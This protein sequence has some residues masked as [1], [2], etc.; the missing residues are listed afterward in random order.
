MHDPYRIRGAHISLAIALLLGV[1]WL[2]SLSFA[3]SAPD[4]SILKTV[5]NW[6]EPF[7]TMTPTQHLPDRMQTFGAGLSVAIGILAGFSMRSMFLRSR[8][9]TQ[10]VCPACGGEIVRI[11][12]NTWLRLSEKA[13]FLPIRRYKCRN[14]RCRWIGLRFGQTRRSRSRRSS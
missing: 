14:P 1:L 6:Q 3:P 8:R 11:R 2:G 7:R 9:F 4:G 10:R 5:V 12:R 13:L